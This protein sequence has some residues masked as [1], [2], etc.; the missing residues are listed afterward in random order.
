MARAEFATFDRPRQSAEV[1]PTARPAPV[2]T[3]DLPQPEPGRVSDGVFRILVIEEGDAAKQT[4]SMLG[5]IFGDRCKQDRIADFEAAVGYMQK[6]EHDLYIVADGLKAVD[7]VRSSIDAGCDRPIIVLAT[8]AAADA[9]LKALDAGAADY[10]PKADVTP[11]ILERSVRHA[12]VREH[13]IGRTRRAVEALTAEKAR[14]N[15]LRDANHQFVENA[16]H[17]FRSPLTVIKEFA[18]IIAEGL[19]GPVA[20]EQAE[21]LEII[22]TRVDHLSHMVDG[23]LDASRLESDVI[24][25]KREQQKVADLIEHARTTLEQRAAA[26]KVAITFSVPERLPNV[27]ADAESIGR[28]IV[29][30]GA[31]ACKFAGENGR[32]DVWARYNEEERNVEIG[33]TDTGPGIAPEHVKLIFDRFQQVPSEKPKDRKD[34]FGLGLHIAS[35]LVR[36]NFGTLMVESAPQKGSTFSFTLP[37]FDVNSLVPLHF[38]FLKT[39][40]HSF[41]KVSIAMATLAQPGDGQDPGAVQRVLNKQLRSYDLLLPLGTNTWLVCIACNDDD[42]ANVTERIQTAYA[43]N[44]RNRPEGPLP[45]IRF[46]SIGTWTVSNR[47]EGLS[48]AIRGAY[49]LNPEAKG[50][51]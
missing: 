14:L 3:R 42:M 45:E 17:D 31:N 5:T 46:R 29:N 33:V 2:A 22:L 34:G 44:S 4:A 15:A 26:H 6:N 25:V 24:G 48:D 51:H 40:R 9:D 32:I 16:C 19:A 21:F 28:V 39:S 36:V 13:R 8:D 1:A 12:L 50:I 41:Q 23:I 18:S 11:A 38:S 35:E 49:A 37:I 30:L 47:P 27:F 10:I 7:L 43:E 20:D